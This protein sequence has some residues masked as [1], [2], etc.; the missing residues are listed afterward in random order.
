MD[1]YINTWKTV[2]DAC[3]AGS[4]SLAKK[5]NMRREEN[6]M[7]RRTR[8]LVAVFEEKQKSHTRIGVFVKVIWVI[9]LI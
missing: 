6:G 7:V 9:Y 1:V 5:K 2:G 4:L 3:V 8:S